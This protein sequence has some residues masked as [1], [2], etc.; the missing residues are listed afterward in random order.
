MFLY[1][2][3]FKYLQMFIISILFLYEHIN[4][5]AHLF[6]RRQIVSFTIINAFVTYFVQHVFWLEKG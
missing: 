6:E 3:V 2:Y 4:K 1:L 5:N